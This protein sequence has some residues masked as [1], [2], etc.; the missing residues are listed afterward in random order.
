MVRWGGGCSYRF[1]F[2]KVINKEGIN[3]VTPTTEDQTIS[4]TAIMS[5]KRSKAHED[6][7]QLTRLHF[8][9]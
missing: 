6:R 8:Y 9:T 5:C 3:T 2:L 4:V 1:V 7:N